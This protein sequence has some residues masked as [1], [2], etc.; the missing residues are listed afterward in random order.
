M[1]YP[2]Y[3]KSKSDKQRVLKCT[4]LRRCFKDDNWDQHAEN[5]ERILSDFTM[6]GFI[7]VAIGVFAF[8]SGL[9]FSKGSFLRA[10]FWAIE[11]MLS[12]T[13]PTRPIDGA[14]GWCVLCYNVECLLAIFFNFSTWL[15]S[16]GGLVSIFV[17]AMRRFDEDVHNGD[18][19]LNKNLFE[20]HLV[21]LGW[22]EDNIEIIRQRLRYAEF[23]GAILILSQKN[24]E[25]IRFQLRDVMSQFPEI[26]FVVYHGD[27]DSMKE[28]AFLNIQDAK[29]VIISGEENDC[30][31]D[32]HVIALNK[33]LSSAELAGRRKHARINSFP[34]YCDYL[35]EYG[36]E[37]EYYNF[38]HE[39][40]K[41]AV[42]NSPIFRGNGGDVHLVIFGFP[43]M[44]QAL[45]LETA[46]ANK[47]RR[48]Y[49][50]VFD[51]NVKV[52]EKMF[53]EQ[54]PL[55]D[56]MD[57]IH[58]SFVGQIEDGVSVPESSLTAYAHKHTLSIALIG[59]DV[60]SAM[61]YRHKIRHVVNGVPVLIFQQVGEDV[62][63]GSSESAAVKGEN[64][65]YVFGFSTGAGFS[66]RTYPCGV[67]AMTMLG[68]KKIDEKFTIADYLNPHMLKL[69]EYANRHCDELSR[70]Y[71]KYNV[72]VLLGGAL[73]YNA[74]LRGSY[75]IDL[76]ILVDDW[77]NRKR[78]PCLVARLMARMLSHIG[79]RNVRRRI[80][81]IR[82]SIVL[83]NRRDK[84]F[85][86]SLKTENGTNYIWHF[87]KIVKSI[88]GIPEDIA[89]ELS[90]NVQSRKGYGGIAKVAQRLAQGHQ[91]IVNRYIGA[92][93]NAR[94]Q[95]EAA[96]KRLKREWRDFMLDI[97]DGCKGTGIEEAPSTMLDKILETIKESGKY[98]TFLP[99]ASEMTAGASARISKTPHRDAGGKGAKP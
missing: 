25:A 15:I 64:G 62:V 1:I 9:F 79:C 82:D 50:T 46:L 78:N 35:K 34:L 23:S 59:D 17:G 20:E 53:R 98:R 21:F 12:L 70:Q 72:E 10:I 92:K 32:E 55:L 33:R 90:V 3:I 37:C 8:L 30:S 11:H 31:H 84:T 69:Q 73:A 99:V 87:K 5:H 6:L 44:G 52:R 7:L 91:D 57:K 96:Y 56:R 63:V 28:L 54:F 60:V 40:A 29:D 51:H 86:A 14:S 85:C 66:A 4:R 16:G 58:W 67:N 42:S 80:D 71:K 88:K 75:D 95:G 65:W 74:S 36:S 24:A 26:P 83:S 39:W 2:K 77:P 97:S 81:R 61:S 13:L 93:W 18:L 22:V 89:V 38:Y 47:D 43:V 68:F 45:A 76:R 49:I 94:L 41:W 19:R 48:L 27:T